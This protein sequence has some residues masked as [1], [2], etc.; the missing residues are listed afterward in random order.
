MGS[1]NKINLKTLF[2]KDKPIFGLDIGF[3][4]IKV[5]QIDYDK[6]RPKVIGY[7]YSDFNPNLIKD[8]EIVDPEGMAQA[9]YKL[10]AERVVGEINTR[11]VVVAVPVVRTFNRIVTLPNLSNKEL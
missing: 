5:M 10:F 2:Y 6:K 11:R 4:S 8:G 1:M 3:S 7:G 9:I